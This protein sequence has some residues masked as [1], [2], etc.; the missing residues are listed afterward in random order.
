MGFWRDHILPRLVHRMM[1]NEELGPLRAQ[2]CEGL[3]GM[4]LEL[5]FGSGLNLP[6]LPGAVDRV[7]AVEP[8]PAGRKLAAAAMAASPVPVDF[9]AKQAERLPL[10]DRSIDCVLTTWTLCT[11]ADVEAALSEARRVV[12]PGG[13]L[14]FAEHGLCDDPKVARWQHRLNGVQKFLAGG[15][16]LNRPIDRLVESAGF[17]IDH[18]EHRFLEQGPKVATWQYLGRAT[19]S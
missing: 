10:A 12:K 11:I 15:C 1:S 16:H 19:A 17:T 3:H 4:V 2:A 5:G 9:V 18:L 13:T 7:E 8:T 6:H 14:H